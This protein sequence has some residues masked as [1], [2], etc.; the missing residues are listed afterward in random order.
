MYSLHEDTFSGKYSIGAKA[1][2]LMESV[3]HIGGN[4]WF[5]EAELCYA[6]FGLF[7]GATMKRRVVW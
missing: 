3:I 5:I 2:L 1:D 4:Y 7:S 6:R